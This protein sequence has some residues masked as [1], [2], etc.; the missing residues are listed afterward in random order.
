MQDKCFEVLPEIESSFYKH[1]TC[2]RKYTVEGLNDLS[3]LTCPKQDIALIWEN[4][5]GVTIEKQH[6]LYS[7]LNEKCCGSMI[8]FIKGKFDKLAAIAIVTAALLLVGVTTAGYMT[9]KLQRFNE[10]II[11]SHSSDGGLLMI[12]M[13]FLIA[14]TL[15]VINNT[16]DLPVGPVKSRELY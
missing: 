5:V 4:N 12:F 15:F 10:T 3:N 2:E 7:C 11:F 9:K 8:A 16:H 13:V 14:A 6:E 1:F